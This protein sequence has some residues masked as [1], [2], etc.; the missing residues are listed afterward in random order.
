M[1][2]HRHYMIFHGKYTIVKGTAQ[3][4]CSERGGGNRA[5]PSRSPAIW[6]SH[7]Q[8]MAHAREEK[9]SCYAGDTPPVVFP[10]NT[11]LYYYIGKVADHQRMSRSYCDPPGEKMGRVVVIRVICSPAVVSLKQPFFLDDIQRSCL[12]SG[13]MCL[14]LSY[15]CV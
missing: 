4:F 5:E 2:I 6:Y 12:W 7:H 3:R 9:E 14:S 15:C 10:T 11:P 1:K 13:H 8:D